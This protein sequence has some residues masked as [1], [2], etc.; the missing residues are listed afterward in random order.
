QPVLYA[1]GHY[2]SARPLLRGKGYLSGDSIIDQPF[3]F[4]F[5]NC[6]PLE[7]QHRMLRAVIF[8]EYETTGTFDLTRE[9]Y[10]FLHYY[11]GLLPRESG[12]PAYSDTSRYWDSYIKLLLYGSRPGVAIPANIRIFNKPG[13]AYGYAIDNAYIV[14][15][16]ND[17]EFM[18]SA[19]VHA[20]ANQVYN[21]G[22]YEYDSVAFPFLEQLGSR[23]YELE[24]NRP[25]K[26]KPDLSY[27]Q[28]LY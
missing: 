9:D 23:I 4:T 6:F 8:P 22:M 12:M 26:H 20:N 11:M 10:R 18:L 17:I 5:K 1:T 21:D 3:D 7:E 13:L 2:Q 19:V 16:D 14:D 28:S 27:F 24:R 25:K 15:F